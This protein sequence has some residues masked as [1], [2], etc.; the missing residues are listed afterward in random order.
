MYMTIPACAGTTTSLYRMDPRVKI[1]AIFGFVAVVSSLSSTSLLAVAAAAITG[2]ALIS[3]MGPGQ[4]LR[5][6]AMVLPFTGVMLAVFPF[7]VPG[8]AVI[9]INLGLL[10][11]DATDQGISR[12]AILSMRVLSAVLAVNLLTATTPFSDL[13]QA[14]RSL[15]V[16]DVFVQVLEFTVRYI[17]VLSDEV[18]RMK[19]ARRSRCFQ[20]GGSLLNMDAFRTLGCLVGVLFARSWERGERIYSAMLSRGYTS[21]C[22]AASV[23]RPGWVDFCWGGAILAVAVGLRIFESGILRGSFY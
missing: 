2:L 23:H 11:L 8:D 5:R 7:V 12:A 6:I 20:G 21:S 4:L 14:M 13:M 9:T 19:L 16:P 22:A 15:K 17:F 3:G 1:V 10:T 18:K